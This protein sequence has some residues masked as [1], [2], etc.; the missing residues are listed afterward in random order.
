MLRKLDFMG[1]RGFSND[2]FKSYLHNRR[3]YVQV[4][5]YK[6][7]ECGIYKGV[8]QGS[9][10]GPILFCLYINDIVKAVDVEAVLFADDAA[11]FIFA[12]SL[13]NLYDKISKLFDDLKV[14]LS[15]NKLVPNIG[16][17]K[18]MYFN[19][20][21]VPELPDILFDGKKIEWVNSFKYL[22]LTITNKMS[23]SEHIDGVVNRVSRFSG[24]F[25]SLRFILPVSLLRMLYR[26]FVVPHLILHIEIWGAS[27]MVYMKKLDIKVNTLLRLIM[28]VQYLEG[29]P[30]MSTNY[31]YRQMGLLRVENIYKLRMYR[32]LVTLMKG[33]YPYLFDLLLR[34][35]NN[36]HNYMTR[37]RTFR[38]P[39]IVCEIERR[40]VSCQLI[41]LYDCVPD[42]FSD[43]NDFTLKR[44]MNNFERHLLAGQVV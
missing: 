4:D 5:G 44:L 36:S 22:G 23:F 37:G 14:Y 12:S 8:P 10:L 9:I 43:F 34:P 28:G 17:S 26:S 18:L 3:Q 15:I 7:N 41:H 30:T 1:F 33:L 11:F 19:S 42:N 2:Y 16:K 20:K 35:Y 38:Y 31:M 27:P 13:R 6:S 24:T 32:L 40:A 29:R 21:P 39:L 25:Y